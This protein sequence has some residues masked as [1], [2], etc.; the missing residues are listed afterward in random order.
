[1]DCTDMV[2]GTARGHL[3][4]IGD[5]YTRGR[6]TPQYD[7]FYGG[8]ESLTAAF[9]YEEYGFTTIIF[10]KKLTGKRYLYKTI[11]NT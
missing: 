4:R 5:Y 10:R 9:G 3:S 2:I 6:S 1:M 7:S 11:D 8:S